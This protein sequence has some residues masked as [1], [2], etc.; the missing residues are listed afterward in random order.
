ME[1]SL[2]VARLWVCQFF[3]YS[4]IA[5]TDLDFLNMKELRHKI[6]NFIQDQ[7]STSND[8][9]NALACLFT[10]HL[11]ENNTRRQ[12]RQIEK[13]KWTEN[14]QLGS[15]LVD[16]IYEFDIRQ[17]IIFLEPTISKF[18]II[19]DT[20]LSNTYI[21]NLVKKQELVKEIKNYLWPIGVQIQV[22]FNIIQQPKYTGKST[23]CIVMSHFDDE[24]QFEFHP[25]D[26]WFFTSSFKTDQLKPRLDSRVYLY[27]LK[28]YG[29]INLSEIY[30]M[31]PH[32]PLKSNDLGFWTLDEG[33]FLSDEFIWVRR[34]NLSG[35]VLEVASEHV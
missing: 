27:D 28:S 7:K 8:Q 21:I 30:K 6:L 25:N 26:V 10:K 13:V 35:L 2:A 23:G 24:S 1:I 33:F 15:F 3:L 12:R 11:E 31:A 9:F 4:V 22:V 34:K 19:K 29:L 14:E 5:E 20:A 18:K 32:L 16:I 17:L